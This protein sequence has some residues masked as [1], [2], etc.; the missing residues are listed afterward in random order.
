MHAPGCPALSTVALA[1]RCPR[2]RATRA[3][4]I[5]DR[6]ATA[7]RPPRY[8]YCPARLLHSASPSAPSDSSNPTNGG[9]PAS[10]SL[11]EHDADQEGAR[12]ASEAT[13]QHT[14][15]RTLAQLRARRARDQDSTGLPA[16]TLPHYWK[17]YNVYRYSADDQP[18]LPVPLQEDIK[19][20]KV[21]RLYSSNKDDPSAQKA[22]AAIES[23]FDEALDRLMENWRDMYKDFSDRPLDEPS[24]WDSAKNLAQLVR[25]S[26]MIVDSAWHLADAL[27]PARQ[28]EYIYNIRPFWWWHF[29]KD[30]DTRTQKLRDPYS[31]R[32]TRMKLHMTHAELLDFPMSHAIADFPIETFDV[33]R[34]T[35]RRELGATAPPSFD[36][37]TGQRPINVVTMS[38]YSGKAIAES[39]GRSLGWCAGADVV[40]VDAQ[41]LSVLLGEYLGQTWAYS[42]GSL[43]TMGFR[44]AEMNGKLDKDMEGP[45]KRDDDD[46]SDGTSII[47]VRTTAT[48]IEDELQK[49]RQGNFDVFSKWDKL[50]IDKVLNR[51]IDEASS[52]G[53]EDTS[54]RTLVHVHDY[55]ELSMT[56]EGSFILSRLKS[57]ADAAWKR[58]RQV[59]IF[60]TSSCTHPSEEFQSTLREISMTDFVI[61]RH[62]QPDRAVVET[63]V[64][65]M[66]SGVG[67]PTD[68]PYNLE[69]MDTYVENAANLNRMLCAVDGKFSSPAWLPLDRDP[70]FLKVAGLAGPRNVLRHVV[71]SLP[72]VYQLAGTIRDRESVHPGGSWTALDERFDVGPLRQAAGQ[73]ILVVKDWDVPFRL[74]DSPKKAGDESKS[75]PRGSSKLNGLNLNEYEKRIAVGY[76]SRDK[77][78]TTFSDVH[79]PTDTISALK[80]LTS[81]ALIRPD[82]FSYGVLAH[83][84]ITGCLLYGPPGTGKTMLAKAV[85]NESGAHM[86]EISGA[87]INDKWVGETEKLIRAVFTLAQKLS[88]CVVFIDEADALLASRSMARR[89][90]HREQINQFLKEWDGVNETN[91][92]IMV[93]TNRPFDLDDAVLRRLPRKILVDLPLKEDRAAILRLLLRD[94]N[95]EAG[96]SVDE[97]AERTPY[98][99]GSDLKS[100]C[101]AA[102]MAAVE[103]ENKAASAHQGAEPYKYP[104]RRTLRRDH[105]ERALK[106]IPAS[107]SEDMPSLKLIKKFDEEYGNNRKKGGARKGMGFGT[108]APVDKVKGDEAR[109][110]PANP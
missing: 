8:P 71:L 1:A 69:R 94:E 81:L 86:L 36:P 13:E 56:I 84:K 73:D 109:V 76:I 85:A 79:A 50:K 72:D 61:T 5:R 55:V 102:A 29:Y 92:F 52:S 7:H 41:D 23:Y 53:K 20:P 47:N 106:Q 48:S 103:E 75:D 78:R 88:P 25:V 9:K 24:T 70:G 89:P 4:A 62:I 65:P 14:R 77:V 51:I 58:G 59:A 66:E 22:N 64:A 16:V 101:V 108:M 93:A 21:S 49:V 10:E 63:G 110:R 39:M 99:S 74:K 44:A 37:K 54:R 91:A 2:V 43:S 97:Y 34:K 68:V 12:V 98:Y 95:L 46:V 18:E 87:S 82:A 35:I 104:E 83:D 32:S 80:L 90:A 15:R 107:I 3:A 60:A 42:R 100:V 38:G 105:F 11:S 96:L 57:L 19:H 6:Y 40:H 45:P 33:L 17:Q 67:Y 30:L 26:G 27:Y 31:D 28:P